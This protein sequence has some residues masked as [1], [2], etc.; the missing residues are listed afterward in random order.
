VN[1]KE[2]AQSGL[3]KPAIV[4]LVLAI[5]GVLVIHWFTQ[6]GI[7]LWEDSFD[8]IT[9]AFGLVE[10]GQYGR[11]DGYGD[12]RPLT[13]FPPAYSLALAGLEAIGVGVY[14]GARWLNA[15]LFASLIFGSGLSIYLMTR[16]SLWSILAAGLT[17][18]SETLIVAHLW[19]LT[20]PLYLALNMISLLSIAVYISRSES[21]RPLLLAA[22]AASLALLTRYAGL[23]TVAAGALVLLLMTYKPLRRR[24][25]DLGIFLLVSALPTALFILR[26]IGL[27]GTATDDPSLAWHPPA[28]EEWI[29]TLRVGLTWFLPDVLTDRLGDAA[30]L[31]ISIL[32]LALIVGLLVFVL[33]SSSLREGDGERTSKALLWSFIAY[34]G[35]YLLVF[36]ATIYLLRRITPADERLLTPLHWAVLVLVPTILGLVW[37]RSRRNGKVLVALAFCALLSVQLLRAKGLPSVYSRESLGFASDGWR[38]SETIAGVEEF[39]DVILYS[40]EIQALY[41]LADRNAVFVPTPYNP[42][43]LI[44]R[45]DYPEALRQ[46]REMMREEGARLVLFRPQS[47]DESYFQDLTA[48]LEVGGQFNDGEWYYWPE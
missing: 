37:Q 44:T 36:L 4:W 24:L 17:L 11:I 46:M 27:T 40:N 3:L 30:V 16:S 28:G 9:A 23:A 43:T 6:N 13:H 7:G 48:G 15:I 8:Y 2:D 5:I 38:T 47:L 1:D 25:I 42:A 19:A 34:V 22:A 32:G 31:L 45:E 18:L 41:F 39:P 10:R 26:N 12:V 29:E 20:E 33:R 35:A 14:A 21:R